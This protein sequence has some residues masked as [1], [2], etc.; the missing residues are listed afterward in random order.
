MMF[1]KEKLILIFFSSNI[2]MRIK[3]TPLL[4]ILKLPW[5]C[6]VWFHKLTMPEYKD[7]FPKGQNAFY[8]W[9]FF[10]PSHA[11]AAFTVTVKA[12]KTPTC[13]IRLFVDV[14]L[15]LWVATKI[16]MSCPHFT[17]GGGTEPPACRSEHH[18]KNNVPL[19][20]I[21]LHFTSKRHLISTWQ[22]STAGIFFAG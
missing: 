6:Y 17:F 18:I 2:F 1:P 21:I 16:V 8:E 22:K 15:L 19:I 4:L 11:H 13:L 12:D 7:I 9:L 10:P 20:L 5:L 3:M 14:A